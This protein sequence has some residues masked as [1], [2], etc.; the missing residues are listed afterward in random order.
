MSSY[1]TRPASATLDTALP[2]GSQSPWRPPY[3]SR[4]SSACVPFLPPALPGRHTHCAGLWGFLLNSRRTRTRPSSCRDQGRQARHP[5]VPSHAV[6][7]VCQDWLPALSELP[8]SEDLDD[9][10]C[11]SRNELSTF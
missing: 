1:R 9:G 8:S 6:T 11:S 2:S 5:S 3:L 7:T 10:S 4:C